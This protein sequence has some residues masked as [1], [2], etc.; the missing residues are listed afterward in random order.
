MT[1]VLK[2]LQKV[3]HLAQMTASS[4]VKMMVRGKDCLKVLSMAEMLGKV[5]AEEKVDEMVKKLVSKKAI[6]MAP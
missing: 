1:E 3:C 4:L 6:Q 5:T 2:V